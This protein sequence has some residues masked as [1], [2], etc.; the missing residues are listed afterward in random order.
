MPTLHSSFFSLLRTGL[1]A[2]PFDCNNKIDWLEIYTLA[3]QQSMLKIVL[4]A[5]ERCDKKKTIPVE[6]LE[7]WTQEVKKIEGH[8]DLLKAHALE[9]IQVYHSAHLPIV[10]LRGLG[11]AQCYEDPQ[12]RRCSDIDVFVG[13]DFKT[14]LLEMLDEQGALLLKTGALKTTWKWKE[15]KVDNYF[16][17]D[18]FAR[19]KV[20]KV[21]QNWINDWYPSKQG[22]VMIQGKEMGV[23]PTRFNLVF[24]LH[25]LLMNTFAGRADLRQLLDV[26]FFMRLHNDKLDKKRIQQL[27]NYY[28][29]YRLAQAV[30]YIGVYSLGFKNE[31]LP[32]EGPKR[33]G[34]AELFLHEVMKPKNKKD[35]SCTGRSK[36]HTLRLYRLAPREARALL[37]KM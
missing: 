32:I 22:T 31:M 7:K 17:L 33:K 6:L 36:Y 13:K 16:V 21:F 3:D 2:V 10:L 27:L 19:R 5:A 28:D 25:R 12:Q 4:D 35:C 11:A 37:L 1:F 23:P 9:M 26:L 18:L 15:V 14:V 24:L 34:V 8:N 29:L 30:V 20:N